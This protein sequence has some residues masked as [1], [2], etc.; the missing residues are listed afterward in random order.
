MRQLLGLFA[1]AALGAADPIA[2]TVEVRAGTAPQLVT[3]NGEAQLFYELH[4]TNLT[5]QE[6]AVDQLTV[7]DQAGRLLAEFD[8]AALN[9]SIDGPAL[10]PEAADRTAFAV[11]WF[12][13][14]SNGTRRKIGGEPV[15][16]VADA[17]VTTV[18][19]D[20]PDPAWSGGRAKLGDA[21]GN[22]VSLALG[23]GRYAFYEHLRHGVRVRPGQRVRR[24]Q[25]IGFVGATGQAGE[26]HLHFHLADANSPLVAEGMPYRMTGF[27]RVGGYA[28]IK[29]FDRGAPFTTSPARSIT[30]LP[31]PN[32]IGRFP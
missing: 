18:R 31:P 1:L 21:T 27:T 32:S 5:R 17:T 24:G 20:V 13:I 15:L 25:V 11:D 23:G 4:I 30:G 22:Y 9:R 16:A 19:D 10:A 12:R 29:M 8:R 6:L 14:E 7:T 3:V 26:P 28:D 2:T